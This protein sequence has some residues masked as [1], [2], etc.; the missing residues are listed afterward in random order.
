MER[1]VWR[2]PSCKTRYAV[3]DATGLTLCPTCQRNAE[4]PETI[5]VG[6]PFCFHKMPIAKEFLGCEIDCSRP[7]CGK[8]FRA[9]LSDG[10]S[11]VTSSVESLLATLPVQT[12]PPI[13]KHSASRKPIFK[14][15]AERQNFIKVII[16]LGLLFAFWVYLSWSGERSSTKNAAAKSAPDV[17]APTKGQEVQHVSSSKEIRI[18]DICVISAKQQKASLSPTRVDWEA[19]IKVSLAKDEI[20]L[21]QLIRDGRLYLV[22]NGTK[23]KI[24]DRGIDAHEVRVMEGGA[25]GVSGWVSKTDLSKK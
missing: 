21:L 16:S 3:P 22:S 13:P 1:V 17:S 9:E 10:S 25:F 5:E 23:V 12:P 4:K 2:C 19:L 7:S 11:S 18:G 15:E 20:G 6:C 8:S 24:L 14:T